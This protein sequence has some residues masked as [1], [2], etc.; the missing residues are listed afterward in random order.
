MLGRQ[1][2]MTRHLHRPVGSVT[3]EEATALVEVASG[4]D[5]AAIEDLESIVA[6]LRR[7]Q[8]ARRELAAR[9]PIEM[10]RQVLLARSAQRECAP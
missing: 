10:L 1:K 8:A 5:T 4:A 7:A 2:R 6:N 3:L 9:V